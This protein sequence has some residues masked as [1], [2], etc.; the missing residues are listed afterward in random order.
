MPEPEEIAEWKSQHGEIF[1]I[2]D[3]Y[4]FRAL[5]IG[6]HK[7]IFFHKEWGVPEVE[8]F[9]VKSTLL[10]PEFE[11]LE[12]SAG[13]ISILSEDIL[14]L[15]GF[16]EVA[17]ARD[18]MDRAREK[19]NEVINLMKVFIIAAMPSYTDISLDE[20]TYPQL[21]FKVA[22]AEK[23]IEIRLGGSSLE[24]VDPAEEQAKQAAAMAAAEAGQRR[25]SPVKMPGQATAYDPV[26]QKLAAALG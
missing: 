26:A 22:L 3:G 21:A 15:S 5:K 10:F 12:A 7:Q 20:F 2:G 17:V 1:A 4:I 16:G 9:I 11:E 8:D 14:N 23:I 19:S 13:L 6:E 18:T 24:L 25:S